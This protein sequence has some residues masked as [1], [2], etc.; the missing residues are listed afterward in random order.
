[1]Y[2]CNQQPTY[3]QLFSATFFSLYNKIQW[4]LLSSHILY[5][6]KQKPGS[7]QETRL[8]LHI[9][10]IKVFVVHTNLRSTYLDMLRSQLHT[11]NASLPSLN[12]SSIFL[13]PVLGQ[14]A[15]S[16][17]LQYIFYTLSWAKPPNIKT[18]N[19]SGYTVLPNGA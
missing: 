3:V 6:Q 15:K 5:C 17:S 14:T 18:T 10:Q 16:K 2:G 4:T 13:H 7:G 11:G 1:M 8:H 12:S 9:M 19:I